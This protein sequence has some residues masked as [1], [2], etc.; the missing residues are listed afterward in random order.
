[1]D[2]PGI[3]RVFSAGVTDSGRPYFVME[4]VKGVP[5][6]KFCDARR[7]TPQERL[8]LFVKVCQAVQHAHHKGIIHRDLKPSNVLVAL[9][10]DQ[11]APKVIDFG[12]A[13]AISGRLGEHTV[14]TELRQLVGT[15]EYMSPEQAEGGALDI[16]TRT[17]VYSLGV[18]LYQ[19]LTG[20]TPFDPARLRSHAEIERI[21]RDEEAPRP[22]T[23]IRSGGEK[24]EEVAQ[25]RRAQPAQLARLLRGDLDWITMKALEKD[26]ARRY[27]S[28][29][30]LAADVERHLAHQPVL[31]GPPGIAYR[32][33]K[34]VR[35][36]RIAVAAGAAVLL[37]AL[38]GVAGTT[39]GLLR[40]AAEGREAKRQAAIAGAVN[41]FL[42]ED[43]LGAAAPSLE[44]GRGRDVTVREVLDV[45]A[46]RLVAGG[47]ENPF[48]GEPGVEVAV[49]GA[50]GST[51]ERLGE[52]A[53]ASPHLDRAYALARS[54]LGER[55]PDTARAAA[56]LAWLRFR[57]GELEE[58]ERLYRAALDIVRQE[59]GA[60]DSDVLFYELNLGTV[61]RW[62][63]GY[64]EAEELYRHSF[65]A[66]EGS[67]GKEHHNSLAARGNLANLLQETGRVAE[68]EVLH[69][70]EVEIRRRVNG[71]RS[72]ELLSA[73]NN[74]ANDVAL[75]GRYDEALPLMKDTLA[76]KI[77]LYGAEHPVT[78]NS[79]SNVAETHYFLGNFEEAERLHRETLAGR[80]KA[81]GERHGRTLY[82]R[83][84]LALALAARGRF[85]EAEAL[86]RSAAAYCVETLGAEHPDC[87]SAHDTWSSALLGLGRAADA[88]R[89]LRRQLAIV[90]QLKAQGEDGG[91]HAATLPSLRVHLGLALGALGRHGEG[92]PILLEGAAGLS[93]TG[94]PTRLA[95]LQV[96]DFYS[97]WNQ[98]EPSERARAE[99]AA[100]LAKSGPERR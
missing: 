4:L 10:D 37:A 83:E 8:R 82:S 58:S 61:L 35:R 69:R 86:A 24:S 32:L 98:R 96:A 17:D 93:E 9:H 84:R 43:L 95:W 41:Q 92:E 3:A 49:L 11:P 47:G 52:Y 77:E 38:L 94:A 71:E 12:I 79:L 80:T 46:Q 50:L 29:S 34:L 25:V 14:H 6:T 88:E 73:L 99:A 87:L 63:G 18:L 76:M 53:A 72:A 57:Q 13:K 68:A 39:W 70:E 45:A 78:L 51:Y 97:A 26:R 66:S 48:A 16:D 7:S 20:V 60:D 55:H 22:S 5:I 64:R 54:S 21:L 36:H 91:E 67:L 2:H 74:L 56:R 44:R 28:A 75:L 27:E 65:L 81:L 23:R 59:W 31:A 89:V 30:A 85:T 33:R 15:P 19:L 40:A 90:D 62:Q 1:M 42:T 100:W